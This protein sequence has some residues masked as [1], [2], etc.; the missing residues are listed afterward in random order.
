MKKVLLFGLS[1][2]MVTSMTFAQD[3]TVSGK[4]TSS[5]D[6]ST[7]P[8]VNVVVK[9]TTNGGVTDM[10][11]NFKI[12]VPED[13][14]TLVFSF[15]GLE[16]QEVEIGT[17]SVIDM[18]MASDV[19]QLGE[20]VVTAMGI[21]REK[22][23]LGYAVSEVSAENIEQKSE[24]DVARI[25]N[26]KASGVQIQNQGGMSGSGTNIIIRGLN[27]FSGNNQPLFIVDGIPFSGATNAQG[28]FED[29]NN[30]SSRFLD[31]DPN[32]IEEVNV[33]KGLAATTLYGT[34]GRNGV[35]LIT[36][37]TGSSGTSAKKSE[38]TV[39]LSV[40]A[41]EIAS[42][43]N[44]QNEYGGGFDQAF[45]WF[46]S[47]WGPGFHEGGA[48]GWGS[49][50]AITV[51]ASGKPTLEHPYS[52]A[53]PATGIPQ[54]FPEFAGARYDWKAYDGVKDFFR[55]GTIT[56][57][58]VNF[59]GTSDDG[60]YSYNA[61]YGGLTDEGFTPGNKLTRNTLTIGGSAKLS[62][63]FTFN[64]TLSY[65]QTDFTA[66]PVAASEG[67]NVG[68]ENASIYGNLFYTPRSIDL[69]N[70]PY[71][72]PVTGESTY[73]RQNN[74][75]QHPLWT[76]NNAGNIQKTNRVFGGL[77]LMYKINDNLNVNY[78]LGYDTYSENNTN[79]SNKG[80]KT[81]S[82]ANQSGVY[83]TWNNTNTILDN[84]ASINGNYNLGQDFDIRFTVGATSRRDVFDQ[85]GV[86]STGQQVFGVLRHFNF[87]AQDE[88]QKFEE[89]NI[90]GLYGQADLGYKGFAYLTLAARQDWV[91]NL[92][93]EFRTVAYP[94]AS[95]SFLPFK[96]ISALNSV[97][98]IDF[99]K[100][101]VGY[102]TSANFPLG[103]PVASTLVLDTQDFQ[104][105]DGVDVVTNTTGEILGN[106]DLKPER[107]GELEFGLETRMLDNRLSLDFSIYKKTTKDLLVDRPLDP[108]TG[109]RET[110]TNIGEIEINGIEVDLAYDWIRSADNGFTWT[111]SLNWFRSISKVTDL[112]LDT[113]IVSYAGYN[114]RGN[115]A[116]VGE[117]LGTMIGTAIAR[118]A[119]G[120]FMV[121]AAGSYVELQG[122]NIIGDAT[123][124]FN[125]NVNNA[126]SYKGVRLSALFSWTQGGDI[127][128]LTPATLLGRGVI[129]DEGVSRENSFILPGVNPEGN[130]NTT[131]INNSTYYFSNVLYGPDEMRVYD[132]TVFRLTEINLSY[133]LSQNVL[134]NTPFGD[135]SL[136]LTANNLW[137]YA[138]N[139]PVNTNF[140]PN[141]AGLGVGNGAGFEYLNGPSSKR[142]GVSLKV[143]F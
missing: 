124:D 13:G 26:G 85:N 17:R 91:S 56:N 65:A 30:G 4:V 102:G 1:L 51:D 57:N 116:I 105:E 109:Y 58:S 75:I 61:S 7:L 97:D 100:L 141:V 45:G 49:Q 68:G 73:Y 14:G 112:G 113:D 143:S 84:N 139:M 6:G 5:E 37:K 48:A 110:Q 76:V 47:N 86:K 50:S 3:R 111:T 22:Q 2:L 137:F 136:Q 42:M 71:Q 135:V 123:P 120:N 40:F 62:N 74:S 19:K 80:G 27:S 36:T 10:D 63:N 88:K 9:G 117:P 108:S 96:A 83:Q 54:A 101:R 23:S 132:A 59:R 92:A 87:A 122:N 134:A 129:N 38:I 70:L 125:M 77:T 53:S 28:D 103:Y 21:S 66:P 128:A 94:S 11:G 35:I 140:D 46:F 41:N 20:V 60:K 39:S 104:D 34:Q 67:S 33:L 118:D 81:G 90:L 52:T 95:V 43:P 114:S 29:G 142:Y 107:I 99:L 82:V 126:L 89:R 138:P 12:S 31:L 18:Q 115:A 93:E 127:Y 24:S 8:G 130:P 55:T 133:S 79:Y 121:N 44:Y 131:Q 72:N 78:R 119:D 15:I 25:L 16:T 106:P 32:N 64:G 69:M 98:A